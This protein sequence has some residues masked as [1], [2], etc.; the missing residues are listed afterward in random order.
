[1]LSFKMIRG[2]NMTEY[3]GRYIEEFA[4]D[5]Y[6][7]EL[8][9]KYGLW[10]KYHEN[11]ELSSEGNYKEG[12]WIAGGVKE[13]VWKHYYENGQF[14]MEEN[15]KEGELISNKCWDEEGNEIDCE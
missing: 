10:K 8:H 9:Y 1:M 7:N 2:V 5:H 13:G 4:G 6:I 15:Y 3:Y 14:R 12:K 11:G